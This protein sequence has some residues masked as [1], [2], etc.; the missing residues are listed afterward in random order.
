MLPSSLDQF[1]IELE[2]VRDGRF[3][4]MTDILS[5]DNLNLAD[6][7]L[8]FDLASFF[9]KTVINCEKKMPILKG[10]SQLNFFAETSTRT[11]TSFELAG[12]HLGADVVNVSSSDSSMNKKGETL[13]DTA[14]TL[15]ALHADVIV[16]RHASSGASYMIAKEVHAPVINAGDG[17]NEH[18]SQALLDAFTIIERKGK[19]KGL[20]VTIVGDVLHS[21]V[22]GS[23]VRIL[24]KM[25]AN[26]RV[27]A[28]ETFFHSHIE[29]FG[30]KVF[31]N[32][33]E[34]LDQ[35][36]VI[37]ALRVQTERA[38]NGYIPTIR[39]YSKNFCINLNRL[40][41]AKKDVIIM[42]PGPV[43]R[44][45]DL[46]TEIIN[47]SQCAV[48]DQVENGLPMRMALLWLAINYTKKKQF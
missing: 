37:Y 20:T 44:E 38:A 11:R 39:E 18:P 9:K 45:V 25:G 17:R 48:Q 1:V 6:I 22:F 13:N 12:K 46:T 16:L 21:R 2:K 5:I 31:Y 27:T 41:L 10:Y 4:Q 14:R 40:P 36:D 28:P 47:H 42:H 43:I 19:I 7:E 34:A 3:L 29:N 26:V 24:N 32:I 30:V 33:A 8:I 23:L 15:D 35:A